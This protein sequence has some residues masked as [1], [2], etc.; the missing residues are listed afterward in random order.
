LII[1]YYKLFE[2]RTELA[3]KLSERLTMLVI[4]GTSTDVHCFRSQ[5]GIGSESDCLLGRSRR[6][7]EILASDAGAKVEKSG[8]DEDGE[9]ECGDAVAGD[10]V[11]Y[12]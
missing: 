7:F 11:R 12:K 10:E 8:G 1:G 2:N 3:Y 4:V 9:G 5:L 6:I